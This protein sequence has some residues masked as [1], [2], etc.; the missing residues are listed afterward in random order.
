MRTGQLADWT[1]VDCQLTTVF[2]GEWPSK[3]LSIGHIIDH[4][5]I[6][7]DKIGSK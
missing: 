2:Y 7:F 6:I 1:I 3:S 4:L 5:V